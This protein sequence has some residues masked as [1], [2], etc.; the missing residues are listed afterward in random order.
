MS[1]HT[2]ATATSIAAAMLAAGCGITDPYHATTP[3]SATTT[4]PDAATRTSTTS[5]ATTAADSHDPAPERDGTV[6]TG[7]AAAQ[8]RPTAHANAA[9][10]RGAVERY[11]RLYVNWTASALAARQRI[12]A[13]L[14]IGAARAQ[15]RQAAATASTNTQLIDAHVSNRGQVISAQ[16]GTGVAA[17]KWVI[18]TSE[19]THGR[20]DYR[21][22]PAQ[23]HVTYA[24]VTHTGNGWV[25]SQ[26]APQN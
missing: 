20:G 15:A 11:A 9:S 17:G 10:A 16:P 18:V 6:P 13:Q 2:L 5:A 14:S 12:L 4:S 22:L 24:I 19:T 8:T 21:G 1:H 7:D 25:V 3:A 23:L 26:W